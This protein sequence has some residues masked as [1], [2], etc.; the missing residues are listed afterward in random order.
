MT[1]QV[2]NLPAEM[3][4]FVDRR[5]E[6]IEIKRLLS[7]SRLVTVTGTGGV[8]KTRTTLRV[9]AEVRK[10]FPGGAWLVELGALPDGERLP[11]VVAEGLGLR[12]QTSR[13]SESVL[14]EYLARQ[15]LLLVLDGCEHLVDSCAVLVHRLLR[16]APGLR[17]LVTS[18]QALGVDG[19]H[20]FPLA[21]LPVP[22]G[23]WEHAAE[24][25]PGVELF[26]ERA[27]AVERRFT[28]SE[29]NRAAVAWLCRRLDGIPL[30]IE[31]AAGRMRALSV[32]EIVSRL[33]DRFQL[34]TGG[35]R[36]KPARHETLRT[37]IDWSYQLC[38]PGERLLWALTSVFPDD[39]DLAAVLAVCT[40]DELPADDVLDLVSGLVD[41]SI[42]LREDHPLGARYRLLDT[43]RE[44]GRWRSRQWRDE[45][46]QRGRHRDYYLQLARQCGDEWC[47]PD[48]VAWYRRIVA[49][50]ANGWAALEFCLSDAGE[51]QKG[52]E[53]VVALT[54]VLIACGAVREGRR[55]FDRALALAPDPSPVVTRALVMCAWLDMVLGDLDAAETRL[56]RCRS[57]V[58]ERQ[59]ATT[60]GWI[61]FV[62]GGVALFRGDP[63]T[64]EIL[65]RR[66][67]ELH[68]SGGDP[69]L[70]LVQGLTVQSLALALANKFDE[71]LRCTDQLRALCDR[72][73]ERWMRSYSD[74][75]L[76][77]VALGRGDLDAATTYAR[78]AFQVKRQLR[79]GLGIALL[80]DLLAVVDV[81]RGGA[82]RAA[83]LL[84]SAGRIWPIIGT[85]QLNSPELAAARDECERQA[86]ERLGDSAYEAAVLA[87]AE[88]DLDS[89]VAYALEEQ[90][91]PVPRQPLGW[92]PLTRRERE[93][94]EYV[95]Q[96]L[97]NQEIADR[98]VISKRTAD[99]HVHHI[100]TKL[101][102]TNRA[103]VATW[104][105]TRSNR[106]GK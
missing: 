76:A 66:S 40:D 46:L 41:K 17:V 75:L 106:A 56:E 48:Q 8:G 71:A 16:A 62:A 32:Q 19:E 43:L 36:G 85:P 81:A 100:F 61:A 93:I 101:G 67:A 13:R 64:A 55:Y 89:A 35:N 30:A 54:P 42:L 97:T 103:Q 38:S 10:G 31:L 29:D 104:A 90:R 77:M 33:D 21:P 53:I 59:D 24:P 26:L 102:F 52:L 45:L 27:Q 84:G 28:L 63:A 6:R 91:P 72:Y 9:A 11:D 18:R 58:G 83:R 105:S 96:G 88:L 98:L 57:H 5:S 1:K 25:N 49:E 23:R 2:G 68:S 7:T 44:Y 34:L 73:G 15:R 51:A 3:S 69:G 70:G 65:G 39:F 22:Q 80:L 78:D 82:E 37:A 50:Q 74:Y 47:G 92:A 12:N 86:R 79:D 14:A 4:S 20:L 87:G 60:A 94:A 99:S 95:A